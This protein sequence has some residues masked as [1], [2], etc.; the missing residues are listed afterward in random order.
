MGG[1]EAPAVP[2]GDVAVTVTTSACPTSAA[3]GVYV[4]S[5]APR[6]GAQPAPAA[7]QRFHWYVNAIGLPPLHVPGT[8]ASA[9][10]ARAVPAT[11]GGVAATGAPVG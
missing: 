2:L 4:S 11:V 7:S 1:D 9:E 5:V 3:P 8:P 6:I 10:P